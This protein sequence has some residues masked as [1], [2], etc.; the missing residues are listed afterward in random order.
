MS[1]GWLKAYRDVSL[2]LAAS[3]AREVKLREAVG[4]AVDFISGGI[5]VGRPRDGQ[6]LEDMLAE[7]LCAV[8][9]QPSD[10]SALDAVRAAERERV[11]AG[12]RRWLKDHDG[13]WCCCSCGPSKTSRNEWCDRGCGRDYNAMIR[14][15]AWKMPSLFELAIRA[16]GNEPQEGARG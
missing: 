8:L 16:L 1:D 13:Q 14:I 5:I 6:A 11:A 9:A 4:E 15:D 10:T 3:Q 7:R 2:A 12:V